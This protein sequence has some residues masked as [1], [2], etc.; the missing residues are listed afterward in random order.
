MKNFIGKNCKLISKIETA[1]GVS[2]IDEI[3]DIS[4]EI[5]I[6]RGDLS[7]N[8]FNNTYCNF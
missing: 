7:E 8:V 1:K 5:L 6:D 2:N 4:D 3:I